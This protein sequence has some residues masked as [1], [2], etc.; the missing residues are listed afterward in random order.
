MRGGSNKPLPQLT[1][2]LNKHSKHNSVKTREREK[3]REREREKER[4]R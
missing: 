3:E 1:S 4:K 2:D